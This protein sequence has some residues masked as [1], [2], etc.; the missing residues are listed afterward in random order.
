MIDDKRHD[1]APARARPTVRQTGEGQAIRS[2]RTAD[3]DHSRERAQWRHQSGEFI[4]GNVLDLIRASTAAVG[5]PVRR[6]R[7]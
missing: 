3:G 2:A 6:L 5:N 4:V 7:R 1:R